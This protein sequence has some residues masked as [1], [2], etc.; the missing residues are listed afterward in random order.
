LFALEPPGTWTNSAARR[1]NSALAARSSGV[2][3]TT[4]LI[5]RSSPKVSLAQLPMDMMVLVAAMPWL[6]IRIL[7]PP[8]ALTYSHMLSSSSL[9][10]S[11]IG[12]EANALI[13]PDGATARTQGVQGVRSPGR[14]PLSGRGERS[15]RRTKGQ[16]MRWL[17]LSCVVQ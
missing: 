12:A 7:W 4:N 8:R 17:E 16:F 13:S 6:A 14:E 15:R 3:I 9:S 2:A 1:M 5:A 10:V 11:F